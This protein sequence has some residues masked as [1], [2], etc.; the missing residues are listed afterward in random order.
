[1]NR[2]R[3]SNITS[4]AHGNNGKSFFRMLKKIFAAKAMLHF[5]FTALHQEKL[6]IIYANIRV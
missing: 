2:K 3:N 6:P 4:E 5:D 1:M